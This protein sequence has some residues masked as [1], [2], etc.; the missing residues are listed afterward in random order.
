MDCFAALL[1]CANASRLSRAMTGKPRLRERL[2]RGAAFPGLSGLRQNTGF[3]GNAFAGMPVQGMAVQPGG[4]CLA[5]QLLHA[6]FFGFCIDLT[7]LRCLGLLL[8]GLF[9]RLTL[10]LGLEAEFFGPRLSTLLLALLF[11]RDA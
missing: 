4:V 1:P 7:C 10:G 5:V 2:R 11:A 3:C 9:Q 8:L 6:V